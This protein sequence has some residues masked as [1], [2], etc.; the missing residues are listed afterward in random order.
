M[1][2]YITYDRIPYTDVKLPYTDSKYIPNGE[3]I[4]K[5]TSKKR[6]KRRK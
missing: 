2:Q 1:V 6:R 3:N 5:L 4:P